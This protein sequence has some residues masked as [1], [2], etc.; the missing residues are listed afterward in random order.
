MDNST[1]T[2]LQ[3]NLLIYTQLELVSSTTV[4]GTLY[5]IAFTLFYLYVHALVPRLRD[6]DRK[7]QAKFMLSYSSVIMLCGLFTL[8]V[9][10]WLAQDAYI[11][12]RNYPGGPYVYE[13]SLYHKP[14][15]ITEVICQVVID[16]LTSAIQVQFGS[17]S[18]YST[19]WLNFEEDM[20][21]MGHLGCN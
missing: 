14:L 13:Q 4:A 5:G 2:P 1:V 7:T 17:F 19:N 18:G 10:A 15:V 8:I 9:N 20:A 3:G 11:K 16:V 6:E 12:H 21:C